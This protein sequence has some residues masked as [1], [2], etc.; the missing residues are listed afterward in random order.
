M[1]PTAVLPPPLTHGP[2]SPHSSTHGSLHPPLTHGASPHYSTHGS[3]HGREHQSIPSRKPTTL[4]A[5]YTM[6]RAEK[7][8]RRKATAAFKGANNMTTVPGRK[9]TLSELASHM[10]SLI[11]I[12]GTQNLKPVNDFVHTVFR[13]AIQHI[14]LERMKGP[15]ATHPNRPME[16]LNAFSSCFA[17]H[18]E[19]HGREDKC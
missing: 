7:R 1:R 3:A 9:G 19:R 11:E 15:Y 16:A 5:F 2:A 6:D 18:L 17:A 4:Q 8:R 12:V 10:G 14:R 13:V